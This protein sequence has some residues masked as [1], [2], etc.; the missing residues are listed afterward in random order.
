MVRS[1]YIHIPFCERKCLYCDFYSVIYCDRI[2][3]DYVD[4][5]L[6]QIAPLQGPFESIY[7][8]GGTPTVL[9]NSI[10]ER[11]LKGLRKNLSDK[12]EFTVE[13]NP[14]SLVDAKLGLLRDSGVN[15]L[16]IGLQ[17]LDD[18]KLKRLGRLHDAAKGLAA[19]SLAAKRAF[20]NISVD[21]IFGVWGEDMAGW[22]REI[23]EA[24]RLPVEH[25]SCYSLT[26]EKSTPLYEAVKNK[27][28]VG[29]DD[30]VVAGM[31]EAAIE[32]LALRGFKQ[33]EISNFA[34]D[35]FRCRHNL[36][37]WDNNSYIGLGAAAVSY[38]DAVRAKNV[39]DV[40]EFIRRASSGSSL[41]ESS[42]KLTPVRR[43]RE[44]AAVKIRT[45]D[46]IDFAPFKDKTGFD[47]MELE[48]GAV[49]KLV[50][51]GLVKY[52]RDGGAEPSGI[53]LKRK[54]F[55]FCDMVSSALL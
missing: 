28:V 19:V 46:G 21:L 48:A 1:L 47:F 3:G 37:Y 4:T 12:T 36:N 45:K 52:K 24:T 14:D 33:Y 39:S 30:T 22:A 8:G 2:A 17:S 29:L 5:I 6:G 20:A 44:T 27:S 55:L 51:Q 50:D 43:A 25:V 10:L 26:Y 42:E 49:A 35:G 31:Y 7:V 34:R 41:T 40:G 32:T 11:L 9:D 15:R 38:L 53:C 54:G 13:A 23:E 18:R 16:S